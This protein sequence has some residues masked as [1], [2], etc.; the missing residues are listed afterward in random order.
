MVDTNARTFATFSFQHERARALA[1]SASY[2]LISPEALTDY[3]LTAKG[4]K[5]AK[6]THFSWSY[7]FSCL[8]WQKHQEKKQKKQ[9]GFELKEELQNGIYA[10]KKYFGYD[11]SVKLNEREQRDSILVEHT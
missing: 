9:P 8:F 5:T 2:R 7:L 6:T 11:G 1:T 3:L 10:F 4:K